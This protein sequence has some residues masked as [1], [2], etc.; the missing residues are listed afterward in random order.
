VLGVMG[1]AGIPLDLMTI[2]IASVAMG[3]AVDDTIHY[4]HRYLEELNGS[5]E[6]AVER[7]HGSVGY[8]I[9]YTSLLITLGFSLLA[10]SDFVPSVLFG[11]L[12]GLA[13]IL[14]LLGDLTLLPALLRRFV[15]SG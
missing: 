13:M 1:W 11:L 10:F 3:I 6:Q 12:T 5:P 8:A 7:S 14:A 9:L 4:L 2:T 15:R